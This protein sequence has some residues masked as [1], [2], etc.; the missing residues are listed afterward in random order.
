MDDRRLV[1]GVR[2]TS[3]YREFIGSEI[4]DIS[5]RFRATPAK[6]T[7]FDYE[8]DNL[9]EEL[10]EASGPGRGRSAQQFGIG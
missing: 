6:A 1:N 8:L 2:I 9:F 5:V 3:S 4:S 10:F 7:L